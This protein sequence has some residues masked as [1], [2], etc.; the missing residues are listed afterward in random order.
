MSLTKLSLA[1]NKLIFPAARESL[2]SDQKMLNFFYSVLIRE[3]ATGPTGGQVN[4]PSI[5]SSTIVIPDELR[6]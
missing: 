1:G 4:S 2:F 3:L 5:Y 6:L